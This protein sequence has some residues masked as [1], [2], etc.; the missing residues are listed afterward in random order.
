VSDVFG[1]AAPSCVEVVCASDALRKICRALSASVAHHKIHKTVLKYWPNVKYEDF[2]AQS[3]LIVVAGH[4][5]TQFLIGNCLSLFIKYPDVYEDVH[6]DPTLLPAFGD[7]ALRFESP[8]Q[9]TVRVPKTDLTLASCSIKAGTTLVVALG[10]ANRDPEQFARP[11]DF[12]I[13]APLR[14]HCAFGHGS[15]QCPGARVARLQT[16]AALRAFLRR[17]RK[18][19]PLATVKWQPNPM[20]RGASQLLVELS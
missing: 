12:D 19:N 15:H 14:A 1:N 3:T 13:Y 8:T 17:Y 20:F 5:T 7:E 2:L 6:R 18:I 10:A 11:D 16:I 4:E 9:L